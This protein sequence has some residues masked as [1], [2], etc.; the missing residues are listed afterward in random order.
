MKDV[1]S[2]TI[3]LVQEI[4]EIAQENRFCIDING[5]GEMSVL[6]LN[7]ED[8]FNRFGNFDINETGIKERPW[9][10]FTEVE[11]VRFQTML[12]SEE[13]EKHVNK[14]A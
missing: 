6:V 3:E 10:V 14:N 1:V 2:K 9:Q 11:G 4:Q 13:Y 5:L 12:T 7:K 8:F